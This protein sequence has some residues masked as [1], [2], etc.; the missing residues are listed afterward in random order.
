MLYTNSWQILKVMLVM[1][2]HKLKLLTFISKNNGQSKLQISKSAST[3]SLF[4]SQDFICKNSDVANQLGLTYVLSSLNFEIW[5]LI[6]CSTW[7]WT[8]MWVLS[9]T[10]MM[11]FSEAG[12]DAFILMIYWA[13]G[14][15]LH[16]KILTI[17]SANRRNIE[18]GKDVYFKNW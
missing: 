10:C 5:L 14:M 11:N 8:K 2:N 3:N 7:G 16:K 6:I 17:F 4:S 13:I 18:L 12:S 1:T 9:K 15:S